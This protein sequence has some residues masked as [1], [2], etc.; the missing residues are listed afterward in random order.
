MLPFVKRHEK[1]LLGVL[2]CF[3]RAVITGTL[4]DIGH[5]QAMTRELNRR[6]IRIF[7]FPRFAEPLKE[8]IRSNAEQRAAEHGLKIDYIQKKN[9]RKEARI[10]ESLEERGDHPGLVHI[11]SA[12]EPCSSFRP[13]HDKG[14]GKTFLKYRDAKCLHYYFYFVDEPRT[15]VGAKGTCTP[16]HGGYSPHRSLSPA[17]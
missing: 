15:G 8:E 16:S 9:F 14:T 4:P 5:A 6:R 11:F 3:D 10:K 13:W 1:R 2:S 12:M 17:F 7:D